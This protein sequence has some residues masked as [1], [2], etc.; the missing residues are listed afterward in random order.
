MKYGGRHS[1]GLTGDY[2]AQEDRGRNSMKL[3]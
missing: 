2:R 1:E 3:Q